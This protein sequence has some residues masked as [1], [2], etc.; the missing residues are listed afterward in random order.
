MFEC[1]KSPQN[2]ILSLDLV[3]MCSVKYWIVDYSSAYFEIPTTNLSVLKQWQ[4]SLSLSA[5]LWKQ[6]EKLISIM[7]CYC[8]NLVACMVF[9]IPCMCYIDRL[10][11]GVSTRLYSVYL[12]IF[13]WGI[14]FPILITFCTVS[15]LG[16]WFLI[17]CIVYFL[18][19]SWQLVFVEHCPNS[20][21]NGAAVYTHH[22]ISQLKTNLN[23]MR[24]FSNWG[25]LALFLC[26]AL[27]ECSYVHTYGWST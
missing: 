10:G 12:L 15:K 5:L 26:H 3:W 21:Q 6:L 23:R 27:G 18:N 4:L 7:G 13:T 19:W 14:K 20:F 11:I 1:L 24:L 9:I 17:A 22:F 16:I 2:K 8:N 25:V